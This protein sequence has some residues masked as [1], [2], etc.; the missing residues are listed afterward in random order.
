M[1]GTTGRRFPLG[2]PRSATCA[3][4]GTREAR[5]GTCWTAQSKFVATRPFRTHDDA[6]DADPSRTY[7]SLEVVFD[8]EASATLGVE[9]PINPRPASLAAAV[10]P[11][12]LTA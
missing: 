2:W 7:P 8:G 12:L 10:L 1:D 4:V 5:S 6:G 11:R 9:L 3:G